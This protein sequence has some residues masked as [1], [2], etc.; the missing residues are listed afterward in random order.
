M[1]A[2]KRGCGCNIHFV[3]GLKY[4]LGQAEYI[5]KILEFL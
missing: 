5:K 2:F 1:C 3:T 4:V